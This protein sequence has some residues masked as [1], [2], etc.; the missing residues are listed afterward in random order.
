MSLYLNAPITHVSEM[1]LI[2]PPYFFPPLE[3]TSETENTRSRSLSIVL[4]LAS[5]WVN[6]VSFVCFV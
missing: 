3:H 1:F 5:F 6:V 4:F 2:S